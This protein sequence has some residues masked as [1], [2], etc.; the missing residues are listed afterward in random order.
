MLPSRERAPGG[1]GGAREEGGDRKGCGRAV[2]YRKGCDRKGS[3]RKSL[4]KVLQER[5][6][7]GARRC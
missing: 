7:G 3:D 4:H 1:V 6:L 5:H 2:G